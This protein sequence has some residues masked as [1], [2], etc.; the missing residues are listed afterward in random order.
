[1]NHWIQKLF[2]SPYPLSLAFSLALIFS[3]GLSACSQNPFGGGTF[4]PPR[5]KVVD[6]NWDHFNQWKGQMIKSCSLEEALGPAAG[7]EPELA[8]ET[9]LVLEENLEEDTPSPR[10]GLDERILLEA[11][12][13]SGI[14]SRSWAHLI[15]GETRRIEGS[16]EASIQIRDPNSME[17]SAVRELVFRKNAGHCLV[18]LAGEVLY[19]TH[20]AEVVDVVGFLVDRQ[21]YG[22]Y[23]DY[24]W[25]AEVTTEALLNGREGQPMAALEFSRSSELFTQVFQ[26]WGYWDFSPDEFLESFFPQLD[27]EDIQ[28]HFNFTASSL[29]YVDVMRLASGVG[30]LWSRAQENQLFG[31]PSQLSQILDQASGETPA[32]F[33]L[34]WILRP[35]LSLAQHTPNYSSSQPLLLQL[36]LQLSLLEQE[37]PTTPATT[38]APRF[39]LAINGLSASSYTGQTE[40]ESQSCFV[41]RAFLLKDFYRERVD[42]EGE[43]EEPKRLSPSL[44]EVIEPCQNLAPNNRLILTRDQREMVLADIFVDLTPEPSLNYQGWDQALLSAASRYFDQPAEVQRRLNPTGQSLILNN[45]TSA[46]EQLET[47]DLSPEELDTQGRWAFDVSL[48]LGEAVDFAMIFSALETA[49]QHFPDLERSLLTRV[50]FNPSEAVADFTFVSSLTAEDATAAE[51]ALSM[52]S[53]LNMARWRED[54]FGQM[55]SQRTRAPQWRAWTD[56]M[57]EIQQD[58]LAHQDLSDHR[59]LSR[60][61]FEARA[62]QGQPRVWTRS[63]L[64][65]VDV[66]SVSYTPALNRLLRTMSLTWDESVAES[67]S[68]MPQLNERY[69]QLF[70]QLQSRTLHMDLPEWEQA[71]A[72]ELLIRRPSAEQLTQWIQTLDLAQNLREELSEEQRESYG[73]RWRSYLPFMNLALEE[74]WAEAEFQT[75][76]QL[77]GLSHLESHPCQRQDMDNLFTLASC[78]P[79]GVLSRQAGRIL[80]PEFQGRYGD[81]AQEIADSLS[82]FDPALPSPYLESQLSQALFSADHLLWSQ[83][84]RRSFTER[85]RQLLEVISQLADERNP[86]Q[87]R[88]LETRAVNL[89]N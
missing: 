36:N 73:W 57:E 5:G 24:G 50:R 78:I 11:T 40:Q 81:L 41:E 23:D 7:L 80:S 83:H 74:S 21:S 65:A 34:E 46:L 87:R 39:R 66:L 3:L 49:R 64:N 85:S 82:R 28:K 29:R 89:L 75:L 20:L 62:Q 70:H 2:P 45:L 47:M 76:Q 17:P 27:Y 12:E 30:W 72:Q 67:I 8:P 59:Y 55:L 79:S 4:P 38:P 44:N 31:P 88:G 54:Y 68:F 58:L 63:F 84:N 22:D 9:E 69:T 77:M 10:Q 71:L 37:E 52:A 19:E 16:E 13:N 6:L 33:S 26:P 18:S 35:Q 15:F 48:R 51:A 53:E 61:L 14:L 56:L 60:A 86:R 32:H 43:E 1:M 25:I 42:A